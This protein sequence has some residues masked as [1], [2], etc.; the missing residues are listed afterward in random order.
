MLGGKTESKRLSD[1]EENKKSSMMDCKGK[2]QKK[3]KSE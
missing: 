2:Q 1:R 3:A